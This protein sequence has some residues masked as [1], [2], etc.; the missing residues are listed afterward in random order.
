MKFVADES[1]DGPIVA[2]LRAAGHDVDYIAEMAPGIADEE[3][4]AIG[5][6]GGA[7]LITADKDFG[8]LVYRLQQAHRGVVLLRLAGVA[9]EEKARIVIAAVEQRA[10][11]LSGA[12]VVIAERAIRI[13]TDPR[14]A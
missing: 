6:R 13:R 3:V 14:E 12:F 9:P 11:R 5:N 4:L 10:D 7:V 2:R 1:V 8:A